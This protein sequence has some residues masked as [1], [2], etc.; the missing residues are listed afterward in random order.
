MLILKMKSRKFL[1]TI[2]IIACLL[3]A[4][5]ASAYAH[6]Y[7]IW[8]S[9]L[10]PYEVLPIAAVIGI[11][12][13]A[14]ALI[15]IARVG[16]PW[17]AVIILIMTNTLSLLI[18]FVLYSMRDSGLGFT[19]A[20]RVERVPYLV[21]ILYFLVLIIFE[22][23]TVFFTLKKD[24]QGKRKLAWTIVIANAATSSFYA[25]VERTLCWGRPS[26]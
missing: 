11:T 22:M 6:A 18:P 1:A 13:E 8:E 5:P 3:L 15:F 21:D 14:C 9:E 10:R 20:Q 2:L 16:R 24:S 12:I 17:K 7:W 25:I 19:I 23:P 26:A 4:L